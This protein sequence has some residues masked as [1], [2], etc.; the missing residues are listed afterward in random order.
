MSPNLAKNAVKK[1]KGIT[2]VKIP[3]TH[4][5]SGHNPPIQLIKEANPRIKPL[6]MGA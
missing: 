4:N 2:G 1:G 6:L 5:N 3:G